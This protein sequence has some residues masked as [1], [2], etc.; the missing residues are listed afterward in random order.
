MR[1]RIRLRARKMGPRWNQKKTG[2]RESELRPVTIVIPGASLAGAPRREGTGKAV[3][4]TQKSS[5]ATFWIPS[6]TR[7]PRRTP[8]QTLCLANF[9]FDFA[10]SDYHDDL[11]R[12]LSR[13]HAPNR[14]M[15][16][17]SFGR[18][19]F[20]FLPLMLL[21][22]PILTYPKGIGGLTG[23]RVRP[24]VCIL[25]LRWLFQSCSVLGRNL[26]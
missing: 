16:I 6:V 20:P 8:G 14:P 11:P 22:L 18:P 10:L 24:L 2:K 19:F 26:P 21:T 4:W 5:N 1:A 12:V 23:H 25:K 17:C 13:F 15:K 9:N 3:G 7:A